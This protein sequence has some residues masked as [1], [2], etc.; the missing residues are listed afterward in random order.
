MGGRARSR[1]ARG[2]TASTATSTAVSPNLRSAVVTP[3]RSTGGGVATELSGP[4]LDEAVLGPLVERAREGDQGAFEEIV[5][6]MQGPI[7]AFARRMM[8]DGHL[9]DDAAQEI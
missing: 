7:R 4:R 6:T 2:A 3:I 5:R 8:R 9:G 1:A